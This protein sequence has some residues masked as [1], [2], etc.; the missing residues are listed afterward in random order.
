VSGQ[1][2]KADLIGGILDDLDGDRGGDFDP[3]DVVG[4]VGE[5]E[6]DDGINCREG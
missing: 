3:F 5:G 6:F 1:D 4:A 2:L